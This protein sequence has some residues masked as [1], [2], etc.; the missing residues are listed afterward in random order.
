MTVPQVRVLVQIQDCS[1]SSE[2]GNKHELGAFARLRVSRNELKFPGVRAIASPA[3]E[4]GLTPNL[5]RL[6]NLE[7]LRGAPVREGKP[8]RRGKQLSE[9]GG[10]RSGN[11]VPGSQR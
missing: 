1:G 6:L 8:C 5:D 10:A 11:L 3:V 4:L 2:Q 7:R 9:V